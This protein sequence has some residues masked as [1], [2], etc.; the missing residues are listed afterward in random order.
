MNFSNHEN[1]K[2]LAFSRNFPFL[3]NFRLLENQNQDK[4]RK[5]QYLKLRST[6]NNVIY[7]KE[8]VP[9]LNRFYRGHFQNIFNFKTFLGY[10]NTKCS[11]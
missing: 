11:V 5:S 2:N 3:P 6:S 7:P 8:L 9:G 4:L 10:A 1:G